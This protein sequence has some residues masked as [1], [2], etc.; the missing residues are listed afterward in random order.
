MKLNDTPFNMLASYA[1]L[2]KDKS[3][4][5]LVFGLHRDGI[6]NV[7]IDS[8]AFTLHN[9][10][11]D[12]SWLNVDNYCKFLETY[13]D[14]CEKYVMLDVVGQAEQSRRNYE[15]MVSRGL[16]PMFVLTMYDNDW[17]Y[18][19]DTL[20]VNENIC[21]AGG[22]TTKG[23][24]MTKRFQDIAK[25]TNGKSR[26]HGL[27][28]VTFPKMYQVPLVS[29][30][31]S[32]W[33]QGGLCFGTISYFTH[34]GLKG[35]SKNEI[36]NGKRA[37]PYEVRKIMGQIK[38]TPQMFKEKGFHKGNFSIAALCGCLSYVQWQKYSRR[39]GRQLFLAVANAADVKKLLYVYNNFNSLSYEKFKNIKV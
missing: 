33:K 6:A 19:N 11:G 18:L 15:I 31:S 20:K 4:C 21:V 2:A 34:N 38:V 36:F 13:S 32:S 7:M 9:A 35:I 26:A 12:Y 23:E 5:D 27:G 28:Y 30:D 22:V 24:W 14:C 1:Y 16:K 10:R 25:N 37:M 17:E 8:G 39:N 3:F 29:V